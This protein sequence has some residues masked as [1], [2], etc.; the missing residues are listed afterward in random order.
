MGLAEHTIWEFLKAKQ[1][2]DV[3][4]IPCYVNVIV[5]MTILIR[6]KL[7]SIAYSIDVQLIMIEA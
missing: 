5:N 2:T 3:N 1:Q 6:A 4:P 7:V